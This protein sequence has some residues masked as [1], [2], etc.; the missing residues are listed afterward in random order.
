MPHEAGEG[1]YA[2]KQWVLDNYD[3]VMAGALP[4]DFGNWE[5]QKVAD[6]LLATLGEEAGA[7]TPEEAEQVREIPPV[8]F[9][10]HQEP[11]TFAQSTMK[12]FQG[13]YNMIKTAGQKLLSGLR[14]LF[15]L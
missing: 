3:E 9:P 13:T 12:F 10:P 7:F 2:V 14:S 6:D 5:A 15:G 8:A 4:F 11:A 1:Y